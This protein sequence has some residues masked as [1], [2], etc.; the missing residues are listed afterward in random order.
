MAFTCAYDAK[1]ISNEIN[2][3]P[4][5]TDPLAG[6]IEFD[7]LGTPTRDAWIKVTG[8]DRCLVPTSKWCCPSDVQ[9]VKDS[10]EY[11]F[12][13]INVPH[14]K[15]DDQIMACDLQGNV[16]LAVGF[17]QTGLYDLSTVLPK[18][19][20]QMRENIE[21]TLAYRKWKAVTAGQVLDADGQ[22]VILDLFQKFG[23]TQNTHAINLQASNT[24]ETYA[25]KWVSELMKKMVYAAKGARLTGAIVFMSSAAFD[26][27]ISL[28][29]FSELWKRC[30]DQSQAIQ[31]A[32]IGNGL[33][34]RL[35]IGAVRFVEVWE[36]EIC[37]PFDASA[38]INWI[39]DLVAHAVP[40]VAQGTEMYELLAANT[41]TLATVNQ[42]PSQ[43]YFYKE[44]DIENKA[45]EVVGRGFEV[46]MNG[47]PL[48]KR[49]AA[50]IKVPVQL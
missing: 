41:M 20:T 37:N 28:K 23:V 1:F 50:L 9:H 44:W 8:M 30:C 35:Q 15:L 3:M 36:P 10:D 45:R 42:A 21:W 43:L 7:F 33:A 16:E 31:A 22:T 14:T 6:L 38:P 24:D 48:V 49:P 25:H 4:I 26:A 19:V 34:R 17:A 12:G 39:D 47:L 27:L 2:E 32:A 46:E 29:G 40:L 11:L 5:G 18:R 13:P